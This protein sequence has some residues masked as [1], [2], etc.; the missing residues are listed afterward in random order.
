[1]GLAVP[2]GVEVDISR[3]DDVPFV[4]LEQDRAAINWNAFTIGPLDITRARRDLG[5]EPR[6][7]LAAGALSYRDWIAQR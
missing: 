4:R 2:S 1:M 3:L 5:F 7:G 6:V